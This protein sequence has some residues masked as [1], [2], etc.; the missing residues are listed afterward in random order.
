MLLAYMQRT[1][2]SN[3]KGNALKQPQTLCFD[4]LHDH[5]PDKFLIK[6]INANGL[7]LVSADSKQLTTLCKAK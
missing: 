7:G 1:F 6:D 5:I 4:L 2:N 3:R